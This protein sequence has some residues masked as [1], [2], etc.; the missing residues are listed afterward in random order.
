VAYTCLVGELR[1]AYY[2][3]PYASQVL[4]CCPGDWHSISQRIPEDQRPSWSTVRLGE[5]LLAVGPPGGAC[6]CWLEDLVKAHGATYRM[7]A[8]GV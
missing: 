8:D 2:G 4:L 6:L 7:P 3:Q 5:H 1:R